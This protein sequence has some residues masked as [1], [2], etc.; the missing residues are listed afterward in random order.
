MPD[1][2]GTPAGDH[3]LALN[4]EPIVLRFR[5]VLA[6]SERAT[7]TDRAAVQRQLL[8][9]LLA[10]A[11]ATVPFYREHLAGL[12][13]AAVEPGTE[14]W[15]VL[16]LLTRQALQA[17]RADIASQAVPTE[18]GAVSSGATSGSTGRPVHYLENELSGA[19]SQAQ[20]DRLMR[21]WTIDGAKTLCLFLATHQ[22]AGGREGDS[23]TGWRPGFPTGW[24]HEFD[25]LAD[26]DRQLDWLERRRP[27]YVLTRGSAAGALAA[28]ALKTGRR[29]SFER[30]MTVST[31]V[32]PDIRETCRAAFACDI[33]D[34]YGAKET[35]LL[36]LACPDC[37]HYHQCDET[38]LV[39]VLRADGSPCAEGETGR[40]VITTLYNYAMPLIRY[41]IGDYATVGPRE[42]SC[43]RTLPTLAR[44]VGRYRNVFT[45]KDGRQI[46]PYIS[47]AKYQPFL[48]FLQIQL[49]QTATD[50]IEIRYVPDDR[51][52]K[53]DQ[54]AIEALV[55]R[56]FDP[57]F[58]VSLK[59]VEAFPAGPAAKFEESI[60]LVGAGE[61]P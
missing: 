27:A 55:R 34:A 40:V 1:I 30:I 25:L 48:S 17:R 43:G 23:S 52:A 36:A 5:P 58:S 10:H 61:R 8:Q 47:P 57:G 41:E 60:S 24:S 35:G 13:L 49:V 54:P 15:S 26:F 46:Y 29:L 53:A 20:T 28:R 2:G 51:S 22:A 38:N 3:R 45:L 19:A 39:E 11:R 33:A 9:R 32:T 7:A 14:A 12:D 6:A 21:W 50:H 59:A 44:I 31:P 18:V 16:P 37:G 4:I 56:Y 42:A